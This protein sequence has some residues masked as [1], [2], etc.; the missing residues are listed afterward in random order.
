M[1]ILL[2]NSWYY[3]NLK[4]GAEHSV[5]LLAENLAKSGNSVAVFT[6]DSESGIFTE[7]NINGV[8]IYRGTGGIYDIR[9][10][11]KKNKPLITSIRNKILE[12]YNPSIKIELNIVLEKFYPDV[13]HV[14]CIAG[15]SMVAIRYF[16]SRHIPIVY[17]L[18]DYFL[19]SPRNIIE[20]I[21][22]HNPILKLFL[23]A[24]QFY[25][26]FNT[27]DIEAV[28]APSNYVLNFYIRNGYFKHCKYKKCIVNSV[29]INLDEVK[30]NINNKSVHKKRNFMFAGSLVET[31]GIKPMLNAFMQTKIDTIFY[32]CGKGD[33]EEFVK[34]CSKIDSRIK[35]QGNL[36][37]NELRDIYMKS[38]IMIVPSLWAEPF[39]RVVIEAAK[40]GLYVIGS[41][42]GGIPEIIDKMKCG[43]I[44]NV[45]N[46]PEFTNVIE[47]AYTKDLKQSFANIVNNIEIYSIQHQIVDFESLYYNI[48]N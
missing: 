10:A 47:N 22:W 19:S 40:Y 17:T 7:E 33:L 13:V 9:N 15:I 21:S 48:Q 46:I 39:G 6:I 25:F 34:S 30:C 41:P 11:Y 14:N 27:K 18:R 42:N 45:K 2:L 24:Y 36:S 8:T 26:K 12:I 38:D 44:C 5:L 31:K 37:P 28:T 1:K 32:I 20:N 43:E 4:G 29:D 35:P 16:K 23:S 3:P